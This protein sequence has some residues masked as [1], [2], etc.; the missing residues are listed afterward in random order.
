MRQSLVSVTVMLLLAFG[1]TAA[2]E[3]PGHEVDLE[4]ERASLLETD[5]ALAEAYSTSDTP[6]DAVFASFADDVRVLAPDI[7]IALG[8]EA[9]RAVFAK[10]EALPGYSLT[11]SPTTADIG[12]A[13]DLGYTIGTY[14]MQLPDGDDN[15]VEIDGKYLSLW[16]RQPDGSWKI[17][18]DMFN[19]D[20]PSVSA[21]E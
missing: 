8:W 13:A 20:G 9:S 18:V 21:T 4:A 10:L 17:A 2:V 6:L 12:S 3:A 7:P 19:S 11:W 14:H 1:C 15:T 16:K 5:R